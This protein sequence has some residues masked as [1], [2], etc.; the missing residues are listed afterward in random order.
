MWYG[1]W[2][3][4]LRADPSDGGW[5]LRLT[6][7]TSEPAMKKVFLTSLL[8]LFVLGLY[9]SS[10][11]ACSRHCRRRCCRQPAYLSCRSYSEVCCGAPACA[12]PCCTIRA[13]RCRRR[14]DCCMDCCCNPSVLSGP[15]VF[16]PPPPVAGPGSTPTQAPLRQTAA[17]GSVQPVD[18]QTPAPGYG[19]F[20]NPYAANP[21]AANPVFA[22]H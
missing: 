9:V 6:K 3:I 2:D 15:S 11:W 18:F 4:R 20:V 17:T 21:Y 19:G 13:R 16:S 12:E 10:S 1:W 22:S 5:K 8:T 14:R 7:L